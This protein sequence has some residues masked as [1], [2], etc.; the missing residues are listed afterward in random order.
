MIRTASRFGE[1]SAKV[2]LAL[3]FALRGT[4]LL[5]QGE[6]LGLPEVDLRRDQLRD[7]VG[8]LYYP[9]FKGRD[10]C[11]TPMPWDS[12]KLNLGF[13]S[14]TPWLPLGQSHAAL[15]VSAQEKDPASPLAF[16]RTMLKARKDHASFRDADLILLEA[17]LPL[18]AFR[19]GEI[20]CA[21]NLGRGAMDLSLPPNIA[22]LNLGTGDVAQKSETLTLGPLSAWFGRL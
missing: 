17:K 21:F 10:G 13:S 11:R 7:P 4:V 18:L 16:A 12:N 9:L 15:A 20:L 2:M 3:L 19:R 1:G 22:S 14:G 8:D 6:E 5:Y